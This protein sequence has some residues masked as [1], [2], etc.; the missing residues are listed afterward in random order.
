[1]ASPTGKVAIVG[2]GFVADLY[3]RSFKTFP[4][5]E[6]ASCAYDIDGARIKTF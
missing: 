4:G 1:M 3:M 2:T 6:V 5:I